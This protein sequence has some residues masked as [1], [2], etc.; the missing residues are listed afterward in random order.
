MMWM[1][2]KKRKSNHGPHKTW[3]SG[4]FDPHF[5]EVFKTSLQ[6]GDKIVLAI[7]AEVMKKKK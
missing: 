1:L 4:R 6:E 2:K 7:L 3:T 5:K